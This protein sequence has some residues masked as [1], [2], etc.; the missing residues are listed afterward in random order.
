[1]TIKKLLARSSRFAICISRASWYYGS[2]A[3]RFRTVLA[4]FLLAAGSCWAVTLP[5]DKYSEWT[6][7]KEV[8][9][10]MR[11][12]VHLS[13]DVLLPKGAKGKVPA[14]LI[15]TPYDFEKQEGGMRELW[16]KQGYA[17]VVQNERGLVLS[18]GRY[19]DYL[20]GAKIDGTDTI[21]WIVKQPWSNGKVGTIGCSSSGETQWLTAASNN[22]AHAAMIPA[23]TW[24]VA[25]IPGNDT[26]GVHYRGGV[27]FTGFWVPWYANLAT[28]ERMLLPPNSTQEQRVRIR[29]SFPLAVRD[30]F[31]PKHAEVVDPAKFMTLPAKDIL[32]SLG[33]ALTPW[34]N[35]ITYTPADPRWNR[36]E[37]MSAE[38]TPRVPALHLTTLYDPAVVETARWYKYLQDQGT[39]NQ[40]LII[41]AGSHCNSFIDEHAATASAAEKAKKLVEASTPEEREVIAN[42]LSFTLADPRF[43]DLQGGDA[44]YG[45]EDHGYANLFLRWFERWV[46]GVPNNVTDMPR[47][48]VY[49]MNK[50][51]IGG[52]RWPLEGTQFT[53]YYLGAYGHSNVHKDTGI[54]S[55]T[56]PAQAGKESFVYDPGDPTPSLGGGCC[57]LG[58]AFDQRPV[59]ARKDVLVY[60]TPPLEKAVTIAGP[61]EAVLYVSSSARDTDYMVKLVDVYPDGRAINLSED[62][63]RVRF[64]GGYEKPVMMERGKVY[65]IDLTEMVSAIRFPAGHRIRLDIASSNFPSFDRNLNTGGNNFDES[66]WVIAEN[67]VHHGPQHESRLVLPVIGD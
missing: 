57:G 43:G 60:S 37:Q 49:V 50:G 8:F 17:V 61:V 25:S 36:A 26:R 1:M 30:A 7:E 22:P 46:N 35:Y 65:R 10:P 38:I 27:P 53:N 34:D 54:L 2:S 21:D 4:G 13:T 56:R 41:G 62:A 18:E 9:V 42:S 24:A 20:Q 23:G 67:S 47:V 11:D 45:G 19:T 64:R 40:F 66:A 5:A 55:T 48:Q 29:T 31:D 15:R 58:V 39:P 63:F 33:G 59:E 32:R 3:R 12:G 51:W 44:R 6:S 52:A 28:T 14:I 16:L